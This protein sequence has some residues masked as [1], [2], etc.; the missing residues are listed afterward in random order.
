MYRFVTT[1]YNAN[2]RNRE[3][4]FCFSRF[5][6]QQE[7]QNGGIAGFFVRFRGSG[8]PAG[9]VFKGFVIFGTLF[10]YKKYIPKIHNSNLTGQRNEHKRSRHGYEKISEKAAAG[11]L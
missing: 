2:Y 1:H 3:A 8:A 9:I 4:F 5:F 6:Y 10:A 7:K 11:L